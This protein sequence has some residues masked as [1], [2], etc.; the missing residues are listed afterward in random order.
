MLQTALDPPETSGPAPGRPA[1][2]TGVAQ[3]QKNNLAKPS[4]NSQTV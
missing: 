3:E 1:I 4:Y 2:H